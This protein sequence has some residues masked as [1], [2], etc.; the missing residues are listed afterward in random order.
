[1]RDTETAESE[2]PSR[3]L[4]I[5]NRDG[6]TLARAITGYLAALRQ[7]GRIPD[8]LCVASCYFNPQGLELIAAE[9]RHLPRI[10]FLLGADPV[11]ESMLCRRT[12][13]DPGP[14]RQ[15]DDHRP[16]GT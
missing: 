3:P 9:A 4:Y 5:D 8:E 6:N 13:A 11:P 14:I 2:V 10:R 12:P 7:A 16:G 15:R 1:M